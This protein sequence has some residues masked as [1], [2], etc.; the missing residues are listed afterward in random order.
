MYGFLLNMWIMNRID[1]SYLD[2]MV[3]KKFITLEEKEMIIATPR[4][5]K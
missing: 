2:V 3:E 4:V 1:S 5:E